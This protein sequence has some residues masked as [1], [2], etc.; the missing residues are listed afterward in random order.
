[1][2]STSDYPSYGWVCFFIRTDLESFGIIS[3]AHQWILFSKWVPSDWE[4]KQLIKHNN[5]P[6]AIHMICG[7]FLDYCDVFS[8]CLN[9]HSEGTHSLQRI[10]W[11]ASEI[12]QTSPNLFRWVTD[13]YF[14]HGLL[15]QVQTHR[16]IKADHQTWDKKKKCPYLYLQRSLGAFS[17]IIF[18]CIC[19]ATLIFIW[20]IIPET[21]NK[22]F[23][24]TS[25]LFAQRNK[26][27]IV[28]EAVDSEIKDTE[29][30]SSEQEMKNTFLWVDKGLFTKDMFLHL[31]EMLWIVLMHFFLCLPGLWKQEQVLY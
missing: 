23:L 2:Y 10:H 4:S 27:D 18:A 19:L 16:I 21:K 25:K 7:L 28:V 6:K 5:N 22:T 9:S 30:E 20:V 3:L 15:F 31:S 13:D 8:I 11:W 24:E 26:V 17:F 29:G 1:M 12:M 14:F